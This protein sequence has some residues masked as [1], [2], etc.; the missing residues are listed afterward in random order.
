MTFDSEWLAVNLLPRF[1]H[2]VHISKMCGAGLHLIQCHSD[3]LLFL[4]PNPPKG[5]VINVNCDDTFRAI[6]DWI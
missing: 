2:C 4:S 1:I 3:C 6:R 5:R